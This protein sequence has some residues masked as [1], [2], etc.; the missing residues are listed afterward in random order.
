MNWLNNFDERQQKEIK[1][2]RL[3][4]EKFAHGTDGHN[5]K[6]IIAKMTEMLEKIHYALAPIGDDPE[7]AIKTKREIAEIMGFVKK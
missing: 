5:S 1:L 6:M 7:F 3:Y 2:C 4:A